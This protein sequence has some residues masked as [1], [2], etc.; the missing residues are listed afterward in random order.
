MLPVTALLAVMSGG[1]LWRR[2]MIFCF[3]LLYLIRL[4]WV[5]TAWYGN[6]AGEKLKDQMSPAAFYALPVIL[7]NSFGWL[8]CLPFFW[9]DSRRG[10]VDAFD[11]AAIAIYAL[12]T[13][14]HFGGD[15]QKRRFKRR[16]DNRGKL[17]QT[18]FWR[19]CRHPNYFGDFLIYGSFA[20]V[21][22]SPWGLIAPLANVLQYFIDAIPKNE[23]WAHERYG[24]AWEAYCKR[25]KCFVP[26]LA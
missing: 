24:V 6:T 26:Y 10:P 19:L 16:T 1:A 13:V 15:Y 7:A 23:K 20:V 14:F 11:G 12:G 9:A 8:Y 3:V 21:S 17:I 25:V 5:M 2:T 22:A 18:G 4:N